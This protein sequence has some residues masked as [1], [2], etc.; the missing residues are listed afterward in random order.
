[1]LGSLL[2]DSE[3]IGLA[4]SGLWGCEAFWVILGCGREHRRPRGALS[5]RHKNVERLSVA[6]DGCLTPLLRHCG[7]QVLCY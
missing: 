5:T 7:L 2:R 4:T 3:L 6:S 1:M